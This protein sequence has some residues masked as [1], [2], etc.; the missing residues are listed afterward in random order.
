MVR[1]AFGVGMACCAL[2]STAEASLIYSGT[3][4][5]A[6]THTTGH[7]EM[8]AFHRIGFGD[9]YAVSG[10][11]LTLTE[12]TRITGI[13]A[14]GNTDQPLAGVLPLLNIF[15]GVGS[16]SREMAF[17]ST[18]LFGNAA[19]VLMA[20]SSTP[21][22]FGTSLGGRQN[23]YYTFSFTPF[24]LPAGDYVFS[25]MVQV[26]GGDWGWVETDLPLGTAIYAQDSEPGQFFTYSGFGAPYS[27]GSMAIDVLGEA[28]PAPGTAVVLSLF[29]TV[30]VRRRRHQ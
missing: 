26:L 30:G 19:S 25:P 11:R 16:Q 17:A 4:Y 29:V 22:P 5:P 23:F 3:G 7:P 12:P 21:L 24:E 6:Q 27:T 8:P 20:F 14:V 9:T 18:P 28:V 10:V 1:H 2:A 13:N 15:R